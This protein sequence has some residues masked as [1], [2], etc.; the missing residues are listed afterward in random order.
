MQNGNKGKINLSSAVKFALAMLLAVAMFFG[1]M[2]VLNNKI[3]Q[4]QATVKI[5][6]DTTATVDDNVDAASTYTVQII[7]KLKETGREISNLFRSDWNNIGFLR[8]GNVSFGLSGYTI[9]KGMPAKITGAFAWGD[10]YEY[11]GVTSFKI[12]PY[13]PEPPGKE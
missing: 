9:G 2:F 10:D 1:G 4:K 8:S 5:D 7:P 3:S 12:E 11:T 6:S 13:P